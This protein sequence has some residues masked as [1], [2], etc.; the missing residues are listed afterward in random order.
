MARVAVLGA[1]RMGGAVARKVAG[2]GHDVPLWNR[3]RATA[4]AV[5]EGHERLV[6]ADTAAEAVAGADVVL[7]MMATGAATCEVLLADD[8]QGAYA[9][10]VVVVDLGTSGVEAAHRLAEGLSQRGVSFVDAPVSGSV[11]AVE[12]GTLLVMA[13]GPEDAIARAEGVLGAIARRVIRVGDPGAGQVMKL[14]V[15]L[16]L[17]DLNAA[18]AESLRLAEGAGLAREDAYAV[19]QE[20]V[21]GAPYVQYKRGAFLDTTTPVAMT[22]ALVAKDLQLITEQAR[23]TGAPAVVTEQ[24]LRTVHLAVESGFGDRDM[25]DL[26]RV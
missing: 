18:L 1:G 9:D 17:H 5:A 25:A 6:V 4:E 24:V 19:L 12:G 15:N 3:T 23:R 13:G 8:V 22:L 16:V 14:A 26:S 20:S 10:D 21:V 7:T 2:A 11:P